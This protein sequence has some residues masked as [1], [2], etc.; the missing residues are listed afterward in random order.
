MQLVLALQDVA[1]DYLAGPSIQPPD[2]GLQVPAAD[3]CLSG[4]TA[5]AACPHHVHRMHDMQAWQ[6]GCCRWQGGLTGWL[7]IS[8]SWHRISMSRSLLK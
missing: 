4:Y 3:E 7:L 2:T 6:K 1:L 5:E 8:S